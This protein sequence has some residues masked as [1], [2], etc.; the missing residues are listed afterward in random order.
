MSKC[1]KT[2]RWGNYYVK[3][4]WGIRDYNTFGELHN[5][6]KISVP[7]GGLQVSL[8]IGSTLQKGGGGG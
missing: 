6:D 3:R 1:R 7:E 4:V 5:R 2:S 8:L